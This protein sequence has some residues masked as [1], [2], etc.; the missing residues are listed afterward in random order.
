MKSIIELM[1]ALI[2]LGMV[3]IQWGIVY[4]NLNQWGIFQNFVEI[5]WYEEHPKQEEPMMIQDPYEPDL[6]T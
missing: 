1:K 2:V 5:Q 4:L 6:F 3:L